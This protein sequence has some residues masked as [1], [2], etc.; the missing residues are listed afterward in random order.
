MANYIKEIKIKFK[1]NSFQNLIWWIDLFP[2]MFGFSYF[3]SKVKAPF[4]IILILSTCYLDLVGF[5]RYNMYYANGI[6]DTLN[7][8]FNISIIVIIYNTCRWLLF[9]RKGLREALDLVKKNNKMAMQLESGIEKH[10]ALIKSIKNLVIICHLFHLINDLI[11]FAPKRISQIKDFSMTSCVGMEPFRKSPNREICTTIFVLQA[12]FA[13]CATSSYD[14]TFL[15][16]FVHTAA[17]FDILAEEILS[18][19]DVTERQEITTVAESLKNLVNRHSLMLYTVKKIEEIYSVIIGVSF[20]LEAVSAC[21][22]FV[23]PLDLALNF[24]PLVVHGIFM[25]FLYSYY[26]QKITS[27]AERFEMALYCCGW[28][29]FNIKEQKT[30]LITL[31]Q[32]QKPVVLKAA[33]VVPICIYTF[34]CAMQS[35]FKY[36]TAF[37]T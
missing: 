37:K 5:V 1:E 28:E 7:S 21:I 13:I 14:A 23:L 2:K 34:A 16:L 30:I 4:W 19:N 33:S 20:S 29:N 10:T 35:I 3:S 22:F 26:G 17:M 31:R 9:E 32:S 8:Y 12:I 11:I 25:F 24:A 6:I 36:V 15:F 18:L 27:A